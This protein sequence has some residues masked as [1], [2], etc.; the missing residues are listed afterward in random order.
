[1][2]ILIGGLGSLP[3][4]LGNVSSGLGGLAGQAGNMASNLGK[5][6]PGNMGGLLGAGAL[7]ALLGSMVSKKTLQSAALVGA[8]AV[9]WNFYQKWSQ[10]RA[11][12]QEQSAPASQPYQAPQPE[13]RTGDHSFGAAPQA[14]VALQQDHTAMLLL[15]AMV[16]AAKA[17][18]H[19]DNAEQERIRKVVEQMLPGQNAD[20]LVQTLLAEPINPGVFTAQVDS[21]E[22]GEDLYRLSCLI[23]DIDH[24]MERSY[25]DGLAH[26]LSIPAARKA[27]L[28]DEALQAKQQLAAC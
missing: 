12:Q 13:I 14:P 26:A 7:G 17:D 9:A 4:G 24:F 18:G 2:D 1:F 27:Q 20:Q 28:E 6:L 23:V 25:M 11:P 16:F 10:S 5:N 8:G 15:R 3:G 21:V 19:I 22:Q